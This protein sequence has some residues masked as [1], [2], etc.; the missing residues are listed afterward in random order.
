MVQQ[1]QFGGSP[2]EDPNL[3]LLI[4]L[5]V[6]DT[7]KLNE[8]STDA[9]RLRLF[10]FSLKDKA[11]AW[12]HSLPPDSIRTW[13]ELTRALL[14][15]FLPSS[16]T[17][18]LRNQITTFTQRE[19]ESLFETW[20]RFTDLLQFC[21]HHGLQKWMIIQTFY[22]GVTQP[23]RSTINA[24]AGGTLMNKTED[25]AYNLIEEITLSNFQWSTERG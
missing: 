22:N 25:E 1:S 16:K 12:L 13:D 4:F 9:I 5:E 3:H 8:V 2:M 15:K 11:W 23:V 17:I 7:L 19:D 10:P 18:I 20:E 21:P 24:V 14:T 6:C